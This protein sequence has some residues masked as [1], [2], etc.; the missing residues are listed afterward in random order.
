MSSENPNV[1]FIGFVTRKDKDTG[2]NLLAKIVTPNKKRALNKLV[3]VKVKANA[4]DDYSC[5]VIDHATMKKNIESSQDL[6]SISESFQ[7]LYN[8]EHG[9]SISYTIEKLDD[10]SKINKYLSDDGTLNGRPKYNVGGTADAVGYIRITVTKNDAEVS[11]RIMVRIKGMN[12]NE[13]LHS[14]KV[15]NEYKSSLDEFL[16]DRIAIYDGSENDL[17]ANKGYLNICSPLLFTNA[18]SIDVSD[19]SEVPIQCEWIVDLDEVGEYMKSASESFPGL[20]QLATGSGSRICMDTTS[21]NYGKIYQPSYKT[22]CDIL[23]TGNR[24]ATLMDIGETEARGRRF[25]I[26]RGGPEAVNGRLRLRAKLTLGDADPVEVTYMCATTSKTMNSEEV[27]NFVKGIMQIGLNDVWTSVGPTPI[28]I[29][30]PD[31]NSNPESAV[32]QT[33]SVFGNEHYKALEDAQYEQ[34]KLGRLTL[35]NVVGMN[36]NPSVYKATQGSGGKI[37]ISTT[38]PYSYIS[39]LFSPTTFVQSETTYE[40][41]QILDYNRNLTIPVGIPGSGGGNSTGMYA[42]SDIL[43]KAGDGVAFGVRFKVEVQSISVGDKSYTLE[44][45]QPFILTRLS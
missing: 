7:F 34:L 15:Y 33:I 4:L 45:E 36:A 8:G 12:A 39:R 2:V 28:N 9:T 11:S 30:V 41:M 31:M 17:Y 23:T 20:Y 40:G 43:N 3:R 42:A 37:T 10:S 14:E 38:E 6:E 1:G 25:R 24:Y 29:L 18:S 32:A 27:S 5:C 35:S 26:G 19:L 13:V 22:A 16:W 44:F 21:E